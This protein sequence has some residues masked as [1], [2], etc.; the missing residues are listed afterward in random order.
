MSWCRAPLWGPWPDFPFSFLMSEDCF[1]LLLGRPLWREDGSAIC[2][3]ICQWSESRRTRNNALLSH[4][5]LLGSLSVA[6]YDSQRLRR[7]Y[8]YPP[9]HGSRPIKNIPNSLCN[10]RNINGSCIENQEYD[11][12]DPLCWS[13]DT[14][15]KQRLTLTSPTNGGRYICII[16]SRTK[17]ME[18]IIL[19]YYGTQ[20]FVSVFTMWHAL[21]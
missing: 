10:P 17:A 8:S 21:A 2:S 16:R 6:S 19:F 4:L 9:P 18:L 1:S 7:K 20:R 3:A 12:G 15:Y 11:L 14:I 5:R 13:H